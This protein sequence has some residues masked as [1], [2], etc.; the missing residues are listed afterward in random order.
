MAKTL[1]RKETLKYLKQQADKNALF[2]ENQPE[3]FLDET[4]D[5]EMVL[6]KNLLL[7]VDKLETENGKIKNTKKNLL[8]ITELDAIFTN[9]RNGAGLA[10]VT[11]LIKNLN[12]VVSN[13]FKYYSLFLGGD[14][15]A[16]TKKDIVSLVNDR[17]GINPDGTM[18]KD[19]FVYSLLNDKSVQ[20]ETREI[21][22]TSVIGTATIPE[23]RKTVDEF[24]N[25]KKEKEKITRGAIYKFYS[26]FTGD[27][28]SET[29]RMSSLIFANEFGLDTFLYY[30][31][32]ENNSRPFCIK[33]INKLF[34]IKEAEKW[35]FQNPKPLGI[36]ATY[37][38]V[39][40]MGG[41][42]CKHLAMFLNKELV[43]EYK[44]GGFVYG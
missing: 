16:S 28:F 42:N 35:P 27:V 32:I 4:L 11:S 43:D 33:N 6:S 34:T 3:T 39:I 21:F 15:L 38:P 17:Y 7:L 31:I 19:Q 20:N 23:I 22:Y 13:S 30:G 8:L 40:N 10:I 25:G 18:K 44:K 24:A 41:K 9:F 29:D 14:K 2:L 1:N 5:G 26:R 37:N 36:D 12:T